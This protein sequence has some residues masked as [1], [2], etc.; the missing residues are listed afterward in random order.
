MF[1]KLYRS[2]TAEIEAIKIGGVVYVRPIGGKWKPE[3]RTEAE[4]VEWRESANGNNTILMET[5]CLLAAYR[6]REG[7][8]GPMMWNHEHAEVKIANRKEARNAR[9]RE[10]RGLPRIAEAEGLE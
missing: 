2:L 3:T 9:A 4:L 1:P 6:Q 7:F 5:G 8:W 10:L